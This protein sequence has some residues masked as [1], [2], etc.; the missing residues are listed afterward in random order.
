MITVLVDVPSSLDVMATDP[1]GTYVLGQELVYELSQRLTEWPD[2]PCPDGGSMLHNGRV[3]GGRKLIHAV[4]RPTTDDPVAEL[5]TLFALYGLDWE[6]LHAQ[7]FD[8]EP[9]VVILRQLSE[10][11]AIAWLADVPTLDADGNV[12]GS[13]RPSEARISVYAGAAPW[14]WA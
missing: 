10:A 13:D 6:L 1:E 9:D 2:H 11:D 5:E 7:E 4:L 12:I 3:V 8:A 14:E